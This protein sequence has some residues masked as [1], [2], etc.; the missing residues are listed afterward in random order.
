MATTASWISKQTDRCG[1]EACVRDSR[2]T[3]WGLAA[4]RRLGLSDDDILRAVQGLTRADLE[5][6]WEYAG[7]HPEEI[8]RA[9]RE[10]EEGEA[11]LVG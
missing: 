5:A 7:A 9:I 11:G 1:G 4:Y 3:V 2:I 8:D 10:N 6:A